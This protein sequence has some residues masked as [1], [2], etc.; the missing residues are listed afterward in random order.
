MGAW[1]TTVLT[2]YEVELGAKM[3]PRGGWNTALYYSEGIITEHLHTRSACSVF[4]L[5]S[6]GKFRVAGEGAAAV[7][8]ALYA[9]PSADLAVGRARRNLLLSETG[10]VV[11]CPLVLR[12][13]ETDFLILTGAETAA[14]EFARLSAAA[15]KKAEVQDLSLPLACLGLEGPEAEEVLHTLGA[16]ALPEHGCCRTLEL[17]GFRAIT[18]RAGS[19]GEDGF[20][21]LFNVEYADQLW[22]LLLE[23]DPVMPAGFGALDSLRLEMGYPACGCELTPEFT[24]PDSGLGA[25]VRLDDGR[26]F[27]GKAALLA[28]KPTHT[29]VGLVLETRRA[30]REGAL[31]LN[32]REEIVGKVTSGSFCPSLEASASLCRIDLECLP[33][34]G[35]KL[36]CEVIDARLPGVVSKLPFYSG[37]SAKGEFF[38]P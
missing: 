28:A 37:G 7:L 9:R 18:V 19:T 10:G 16:N 2:E 3:T 13:A 23:T 15:G 22:D 17:D 8:D 33:G 30:A 4:D 29:L 1:K 32:E 38:L 34:E 6:D 36:F 20:R 25:L 12:M 14:A 31:V 24:P 11:D 27:A 5:C 21:L 35:E 26:E